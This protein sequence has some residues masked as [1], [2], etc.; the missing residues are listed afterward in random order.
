MSRARRWVVGTLVAA[1]RRA[2]GGARPRPAA[3]GVAPAD[4]RRPVERAGASAP[5]RARPRVPPERGRGV[6]RAP[7]LV[8]RA[9][10]AAAL[11]RPRRAASSTAC[12]PLAALAPRGALR[13][14][15]GLAAAAAH[16]AH[17][18]SRPSR[19]RTSDARPEAA[20][21]GP[22]RGPAAHARGRRAPRAAPV[23]HVLAAD[24]GAR[25][26]RGPRPRSGPG[27]ALAAAARRV[28][29]GGRRRRWS[30]S[31]RAASRWR[32][33]TGSRSRPARAPPPAGRWRAPRVWSFSTPPPRLVARHPEGGPA[34]RDTLMLAVFDQAVD[35]AA[36]VGSLRVRAGGA[37]VPVRLATA[38]EVA[39]GRGRRSRCEGRPARA[40]RRVPG[41][42][43]HAR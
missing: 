7:V 6:G 34:R 43:L 4:A 23:G 16:R 10:A 33:S 11:A 15:R 3:T 17:A 35:P 2:G 37:T 14:P 25:L 28:A 27:P 19:P 22:A 13:D 39:G 24:G 12:R 30:S 9:A 38:A 42:A 1:S 40:R 5:G 32:R 29:L 20:R 26:A 41:R 31:P 18:C 21:H 8:A 36:V